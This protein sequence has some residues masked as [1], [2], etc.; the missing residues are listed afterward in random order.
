MAQ[1]EQQ[2]ESIPGWGLLMD[3]FNDYA[4]EHFNNT[5]PFEDKEGKKRRLGLNSS[6]EERKAWKSIQQKAWIHDKCFLGLCGIGL[7]F[8][9]GLVPLAV[10]LLPIAGPI[11]M[12]IIHSRILAIAHEHLHI[13][14]KM[15]AKMQANIMF[16]LLISLPPVIGAFFSWLHGCLTRN[17]GM[18][19]VYLDFLAQKRASGELPTY[20]GAV[21]PE[22]ALRTHPTAEPILVKAAVP[23]A[24]KSTKFFGKKKKE[25]VGIE[26]GTMQQGVR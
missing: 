10:F 18:L 22:A 8:G 12:Y 3:A 20:I 16:D 21:P 9:L 6:P 26:V 5:N 15:E 14:V 25:E 4:E 24:P 1:I 19:Y 13:P 2:L 7:D 23:P 17:A 11:V